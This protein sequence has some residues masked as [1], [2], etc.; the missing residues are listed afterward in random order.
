VRPILLADEA[1]EHEGRDHRRHAE[2]SEDDDDNGG[3]QTLPQ[4]GPADP[5]APVP[6]NG[7]FDGKARPKVQV[8]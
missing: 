6:D 2:D 1:R 3:L 4:N 5:N 7:L 8:Q